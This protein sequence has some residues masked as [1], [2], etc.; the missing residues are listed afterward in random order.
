M[1]VKDSKE[2]EAKAE[3]QSP[4]KTEP[5]PK[6]PKP[7]SSSKPKSPSKNEKQQTPSIEQYNELKNQLT[8]QILKKQELDSQLGTLESTIYD[9]ETEYFN[10][11]IYGNIVRGFE[12]FSKNS[13]GGSAGSMGSN[14]RRLA[15]T[16]DDHIFSLSSI[17][18]VK[19]LMKRQGLSIND[20]YQYTDSPSSNSN[21]PTKDDFD[22]YEDSV[23]PNIGKDP[24]SNGVSTESPATTPGTP[25]SS[26]IPPRKR[27][28]RA[29][30][31]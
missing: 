17:N 24:K 2:K 6:S 1:S 4:K 18:F 27:K 23:D 19:T 31:D 25:T 3:G 13:G 14:K 7:K 12:N 5:V 16:D 26:G 10:E 8:Q 20:S 30:D 29:L 11:S 21:N 9:K 28:A 15:Y 22:D